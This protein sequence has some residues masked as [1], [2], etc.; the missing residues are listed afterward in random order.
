MRSATRRLKVWVSGASSGIGFAL[1]QRLLE[2]GYQVFASA[3]N[4]SNLEALARQYSLLIPLSFDVTDRATLDKVILNAGNCEYVDI[5]TP[6]WA[7][8]KRIIDVTMVLPGF[9]K[10]PLTDKNNFSMPFLISADEPANRILR[11]LALRPKQYLSPKRLYLLLKM[12][13]L[14]PPVWDRVMM[15]SEARRAA[16]EAEEIS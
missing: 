6:D 1:T 3:R 12:A 11:G 10:T 9:V 8:F 2:E 15:A 14:L 16:N 13:Q 5:D 7:A 4:V